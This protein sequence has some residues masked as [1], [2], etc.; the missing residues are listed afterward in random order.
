MVDTFYRYC[1][2][3]KSKSI[4]TFALKFRTRYIKLCS[5]QENNNF[6]DN[7]NTSL[8]LKWQFAVGVRDPTLR[9]YALD[10]I[11]RGRS[12]LR[13]VSRVENA[14]KELNGI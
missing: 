7:P 13:L 4:R 8:E 6:S 3:K 14:E 2:R 12:F 11:K 1:Q 9:E 10:S 5:H